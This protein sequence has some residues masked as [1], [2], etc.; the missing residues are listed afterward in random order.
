M[1]KKIIILFV[2]LI[3]AVIPLKAQ[4]GVNT[5]TPAAPSIMEINSA[6][7]GVLLP[8]VNISNLTN[9]TPITAAVIPDGILVYN[10]GG[11][12]P[13]TNTNSQTF[14]Y[15]DVAANAGTG[16]W[17][18]HLYFKETPKVAT[19]GMINNKAL[20][21][22][23]QR[24]AS[25]PVSSAANN[26]TMINSGYMP[27]LVLNNNGGGLIAVGPG[28]YTL[29]ISY[30]LNAPPANPAANGVILKNGYYNMGYLSDL[31]IWPFNPNNSTYDPIF[32]AG[33]VEGAVL[34]KISTDH[35]IRF[36]HTFAL[37]GVGRV[38]EIDMYLGR[39]DGTT[40]YDLVNIIASG[41]I[42]KL[43]KLN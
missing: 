29:E 16:A 22:N 42:I 26:F 39:R 9:K 36:L 3:N 21:D 2:L 33:R 20:L 41:T 31:F 13:N 34:S 38:F 1:M 32:F 43:T 25:E 35:R 23:A 12:N 5:R 15:W 19:I 10:S 40:F 6:N 27:G 18:R 30:L 28:T 8:R 17:L 7:K 4:T 37:T 14:Y 11:V 24:G